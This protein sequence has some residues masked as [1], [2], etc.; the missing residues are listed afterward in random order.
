M[1]LDTVYGVHAV[2]SIKNILFF[3]HLLIL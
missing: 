3:P 2:N 1:L